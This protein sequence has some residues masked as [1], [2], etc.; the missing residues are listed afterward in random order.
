MDNIN[1]KSEV[2]YE[3]EITRLSELNKLLD[4]FTLMFGKPAFILLFGSL[5]GTGQYGNSSIAGWDGKPIR[6]HFVEGDVAI[7]SD[8]EG[9]E[10]IRAGVDVYRTNLRVIIRK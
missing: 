8:Y 4:A 10:V 6:F 2:S 9:R 1:Y 3:R 5:T 7:V